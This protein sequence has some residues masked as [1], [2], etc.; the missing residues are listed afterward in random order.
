MSKQCWCLSHPKPPLLTKTPSPNRL[1]WMMGIGLGLSVYLL[2]RASAAGW[3]QGWEGCRAEGWARS[4]GTREHRHQGGCSALLSTASN[5][6]F[7]QKASCFRW[8][9]LTP[10]TGVPAEPTLSPQ[11]PQA[12]WHALQAEKATRPMCARG[13]KIFPFTM[14]K[15]LP[16]NP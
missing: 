13:L 15:S 11:P 4:V 2:P 3:L 9:P 14:I 6:T 16:R 8:Q 10:R 5:H 7:T 12:G 1:G